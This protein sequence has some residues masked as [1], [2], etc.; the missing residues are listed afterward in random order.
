MP[1]S[2]RRRPLIKFNEFNPTQT[3]IEQ[4][5]FQFDSV[6]L[7]YFGVKGVVFNDCVQYN[8]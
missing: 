5:F 6:I 2:F 8:D 1:S 3:L 7:G 4:L